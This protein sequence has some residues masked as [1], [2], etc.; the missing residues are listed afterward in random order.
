MCRVTTVRFGTQITPHVIFA[1]TLTQRL[2]PIV[3]LSLIALPQSE[4]VVKI[5]TTDTTGTL[6]ECVRTS[7]S[8]TA[9]RTC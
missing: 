8:I 2:D 5:A 6:K 4:T 9:L 1:L 7:L 3:F